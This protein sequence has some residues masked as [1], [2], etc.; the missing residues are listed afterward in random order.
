MTT[1]EQQ[2]QS[3]ELIKTLAH[4]AWE[5]SSFKDELVKNPVSTIESVM[6]Y[7]LAENAKVIVEDQTNAS[8]FFLNIPRKPNLDE[9][10][11]T[12]EQLEMISGGE[13]VIIATVGLGIACVGLFAAGIAIGQAID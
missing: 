12:D 5:S 2:K 10:E 1:L 13:L 11:L 9:M 3:A 4:K 8:F 6:G 7:K